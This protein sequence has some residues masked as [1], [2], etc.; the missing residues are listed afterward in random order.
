MAETLLLAF[1]LLLIFEGLLPF[2]LPKLWQNVMR[3]AS[4]MPENNLRI[5]GM[6]SIAIGMLMLFWLG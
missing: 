1:A 2:A 5:M 6:I 3:E 4:Q